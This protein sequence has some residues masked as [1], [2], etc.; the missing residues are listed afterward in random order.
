MSRLI[1]NVH[2]SA[3]ILVLLTLISTLLAQSNI[4]ENLLAVL[5]TLSVVI[6]GQQI[7][8]IFMELNKVQA[9]WRWFLLSYT[10]LI[11]TILAII[12]YI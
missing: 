11:P 3:I 5:V 7:V 4:Q 1:N 2:F 10:I 8:D 6:K 12:I 9:K